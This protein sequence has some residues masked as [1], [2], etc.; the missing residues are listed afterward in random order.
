MSKAKKPLKL[1]FI[2]VPSGKEGQGKLKNYKS[3]EE[4]DYETEE[5]CEVH[6]RSLKEAKTLYPQVFS[7]WQEAQHEAALKRVGTQRSPFGIGS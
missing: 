7:D 2:G 6:A 4:A 3:S 5:W 1:F